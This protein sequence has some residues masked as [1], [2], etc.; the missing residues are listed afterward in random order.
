MAGAP[1][2][3]GSEG[4]VPY[5][6]SVAPTGAPNAKVTTQASPQ[7]FGAQ[8]GQGIE[9]VGEA[10]SGVTN[11][12]GGMIMETAAN[13]AELGYQKAAGELHAKYTQLEGLAAEAARPQYTADL[14]AAQQQYRANLPLAAQHMFDQNTI[15]QMGNQVNEYS[16]YAAGQIKSANL[17]TQKALQ[18]NAANTMGNLASVTND[19]QVGEAVGTV[20]HAHNAISD[21]NGDASVAT[22]VDKTT[23]RLTF[24][25]TPQGQAAS[26]RYNQGLDAALA[27]IFMNGAKTVTDNQGAT[28]GADWAK[29]HWDMMPDIAKVQMNQFL[30][31]KMVNEDIDGAIATANSD[32]AANK[33]QQVLSN[34][35]SSPTAPLSVRNNNPGNLR[36]QA[37][38]EFRVFK[39]PEEGA[40]AMQADL[41]AKVS[42]NSPAMEK[43]FGKGYSPTLSNVITTY[44]PAGDKN[45]P[46]AYTDTVS[47]ETGIAP[48]QVLTAADIP[49]LQAAMTKVEAGGSGAASK[50][51]SNDYERLIDNR[52]SFIDSAVNNITEKRGSDLGLI[53]T[54]QKRAEAN[55]DAQIR[56][57]K[58]ALDSDQKNVQDAIEGNRTKGQVPMTIED[59]RSVQG[60]AP[61]IDKVQREQPEFYSSLLTRIAKAQHADATQNSPNAYDAIQATLDTSKPYSRQEQ[62]EYLSK[63]LGSENPGYSISQKDYNDAKSAIDLTDG[64]DTLST[65][66]KQ[67]AQA[68]GDLDGKGQER[69]VQW[70]NQVMAA[71]K[72]NQADEKG[73]MSD[74][75]FFDSTKNQSLPA[76]IM[77]SRIQQLQNVAQERLKAGAIM[78]TKPDGTVGTVL[79]DRLDDALKAGYKRVQ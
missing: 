16:N 66:M 73:K 60:I 10:A 41:T 54:T 52:Q 34:V 31:P 22:G 72:A 9:K 26:A 79:P 2:P 55:I 67:I 44:A 63:G 77:P 48:N 21:I 65:T 75:D 30:A 8:V 12:Y 35:P 70:Y 18:V 51:Y 11:L 6:P 17:G 69:A 47:K 25:D 74:S 27:P 61:L 46:K 42:G 58:G 39:T 57:A 28:A 76:P 59:L 32:M 4:S 5:S 50:Q 43:N 53:A 14:Q 38:R 1:N 37:T 71:R 36:D 68:N 33:Q 29:K 64:K 45:D 13:Q 24:P 19:T 49:K 15:R 7:D 23:G 56:V 20:I 3:Y 40:A 78:V 62:I